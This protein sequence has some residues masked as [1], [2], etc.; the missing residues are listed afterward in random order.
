MIQRI[1]HQMEQSETWKERFQAVDQMTA[2]VA[3]RIMELIGQE[4]AVRDLIF[5][6]IYE[7]EKLSFQIG[8]ESAIQLWTESLTGSDMKMISA[9]SSRNQV[10]KQQ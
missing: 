6:V 7:A 9:F 4:E 2:E 1:F 10:E 3:P 5:S 8:F